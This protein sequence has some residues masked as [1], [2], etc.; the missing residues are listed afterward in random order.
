MMLKQG[1]MEGCKNVYR[2]SENPAYR[3]HL[4]NLLVSAMINKINS[5]EKGE[6]KCIDRLELN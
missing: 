6:I 2:T 4:E 3:T 5:L 1:F